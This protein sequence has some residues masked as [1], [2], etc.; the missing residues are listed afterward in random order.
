M[1]KQNSYSLLL[2][3]L[4]GRKIKQQT[5]KQT[6][7]QTNKQN[8]TK[9]NKTKEKKTNK[10][11]K[12]KQNKTKQNKTNKQTNKQT[13]NLVRLRPQLTH[14]SPPNLWIF[15][16]RVCFSAEI[17]NAQFPP[18]DTRCPL[19]RP[20]PKKKSTLNTWWCKIKTLW[21]IHAPISIHGRYPF[22]CSDPR[23]LMLHTGFFSAGPNRIHGFFLYIKLYSYLLYAQRL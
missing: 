14:V 3:K 6:N 12:T 13:N 20:Q 2:D 17:S 18:S 21:P 1:R 15:K 5:N 10:Q 11:N 23:T 8:K 19:Q 16:F 22:G 9:Q 7:R 4:T